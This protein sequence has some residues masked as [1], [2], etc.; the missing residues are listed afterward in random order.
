M[1]VQA[2]S[3]QI[4]AKKKLPFHLIPCPFSLRTPDTDIHE[5]NFNNAIAIVNFQLYSTHDIIFSMFMNVRES[6]HSEKKCT[7]KLKVLNSNSFEKHFKIPASISDPKEDFNVYLEAPIDLD[8]LSQLKKYKK[9]TVYNS[10]RYQ[11]VVRMVIVV[12][13]IRKL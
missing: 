13:T 8:K 10:E 5:A 6:E 12:L 2:P 11:V 3:P 4:P 1:P 9:D 7:Q